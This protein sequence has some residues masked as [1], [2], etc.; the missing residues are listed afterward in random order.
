MRILPRIILLASVVS[1]GIAG[2]CQVDIED[3]RGY[4]I[5]TPVTVTGIVTNGP[6]LGSIRYIQDASA[7]IAV[8]PGSGSVGGFAPSPGQQIIVTGILKEFNGLLEI[9]PVQSYQ[10]IS[11]GNPLPDP[12]TVTPDGLDESVEGM[13][14]QVNGCQFQTSGTFFTGTFAFNSIGETANLY[15]N[16]G[17]PISGT[18]IPSG[19][20]S[21]TGLC[22]QYDPGTPAYQGYQLLARGPSDITASTMIHL[23]SGVLQEDILPDG[24]TLR[25]HTDLPGSSGVRYG[26]GPALGT[27]M[28]VPGNTLQ[29]GISLS[30]LDPATIYHARVFSVAGMDTAFSSVGI[31]STASSQPGSIRAYFNQ[32][33][34]NSVSLGSNATSIGAAIVDT[35]AAVIGRAEATIEVAVYNVNSY[36]LVGALNDAV[37]R[38]VD[39]RYI[40]EGQNSNSALSILDPAVPVLYRTNATGSGMHNKFLVVDADD[41]LRAT[42]LTGSTNWTQG[43]LLTDPNNLV[44]VQDQALAR[45]YRVEFEEMWGGSGSQPDLG[46][47]RFG[48]SKVDNTPH[49]FLIG[50][51]PV[52]CWFSPSDGVTGRIRAQIDAAEQSIGIA[53]FIQT[54]NSLRDALIVAMDRGVSVS[55]IVDD[56]FA[57]GSDFTALLNAGADIYSDDG[58]QR[59]VHHKYAIIDHAD[60]GLDP[61]VITGSHNWTASAN[62]VN[63]ENTLVIH[64]PAIAD[65]FHQEW[66]ALRNTF[67]G[68]ASGTGTGVSIAYPMPCSDVLFLGWPAATLQGLRCT[69]MLG[70]ERPLSAVSFGPD[71]IAVDVDDLPP[72]GYV[73]SSTAADGLR[74][75]RFVKVD[76]RP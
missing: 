15:V 75:L 62:S 23:A 6:E 10:V 19:T 66:T 2:R 14:V 59:L 64:D 65:Q 63:D 21:I 55:G 46:N 28:V 50:G 22:S 8:Y 58:L 34:D 61:V 57:P 26:T 67:T 52:E 4:A 53:L 74:P 30:G 25:W 11:S 20:V 72:G 49:F 36:T 32:A 51:I 3:A 12:V 13:L 69:D 71:L 76:R 73:L 35:I 24:F 38:G 16:S 68:I 9:D 17:N 27:T 70:R 40:A 18:V 43:N 42:V 5:G 45:T 1:M 33:V 31:Y 54:E 56:V 47:S 39:V 41:P 60:P 44:I 37:D 7:G 29:H 48:A